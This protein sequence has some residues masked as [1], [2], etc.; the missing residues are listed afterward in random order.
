MAL[1]TIF[2]LVL[3]SISD[4][5]YL[6]FMFLILIALIRSNLDMSKKEKEY[7]QLSHSRHQRILDARYK[8]AYED[9][10]LAAQKA[11]IAAKAKAIPKQK[12]NTLPKI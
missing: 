2:P 4:S 7:Q 8:Q 3:L 11:E 9:Q 6:A 5:F 10:M 12:K 1:T